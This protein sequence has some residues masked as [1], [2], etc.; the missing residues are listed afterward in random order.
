MNTEEKIEKWLAGELSDEER[1]EFESTDE[2]AELARLL[3]ALKHFKAPAYD[4]DQQYRKLSDH[5]MHEAK[6]ISL[7]GRFGPVLRIA[8]IFI[9]ALTIGYFS[10]NQ[11][12]SGLKDRDWIA[13]QD[14][15]LLPDSSLVRL[16]AESKIRFS[17]KK[18]EK[19][20][21]VEFK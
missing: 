7:S 10:Y 15:I 9:V 1:R 16:N 8:A 20:R 21:N 19:E 2:F 6:T 3:K 12:N 4:V 13:A 11:L 17:Y 14:E 18:W 5:A